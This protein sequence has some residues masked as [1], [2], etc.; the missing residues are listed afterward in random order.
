MLGNCKNKRIQRKLLKVPT[1]ANSKEEKFL[2]KLTRQDG[3]TGQP[4]SRQYAKFIRDC[5]YYNVNYDPSIFNDR[6]NNESRCASIGCIGGINSPLK[7]HLCFAKPPLLN[8]QTVQAPFLD[9]SP[10]YWFFLNLPFPQ[11]LPLKIGFFSEPS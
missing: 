11:Q 1:S 6:E 7:K 8:L 2:A 9:N 3:E 4:C 5:V 10:I